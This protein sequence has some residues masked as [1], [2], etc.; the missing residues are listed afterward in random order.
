M[1]EE[2]TKKPLPEGDSFPKEREQPSAEQGKPEMPSAEQEHK[3]TPKYSKEKKES[4]KTGHQ[5][6]MVSI[7]GVTIEIK[8]TKFIYERNRTATFYK[9]LELYPVGEIFHMT[10][11]QIGDGRDGDKAVFDWLIAVTD[12]EELIKQKYDE[13]DQ[14]TVDKQVEIYK[15]VNRIQEKEERL[16]NLMAPRKGA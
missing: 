1:A 15:R 14:T 8:P 11:E 12:N 9:I 3:K 16:K 6:N 13:I 4:P 7:G 5:E 2:M 10:P